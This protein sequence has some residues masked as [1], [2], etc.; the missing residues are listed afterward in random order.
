MLCAIAVSVS[1]DLPIFSLLV[2]LGFL[3]VSDDFGWSMFILY[4]SVC[5]PMRSF[6]LDHVSQ[7]AVA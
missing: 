2:L 4:T 5:S 6:S 3:V 1:Q 7:I